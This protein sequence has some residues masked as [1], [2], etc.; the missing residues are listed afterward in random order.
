M[1]SH[2]TL[3]SIGI[4]RNGDNQAGNIVN[5]YFFNSQTLPLTKGLLHTCLLLKDLEGR[6][7]NY[8]LRFFH[9]N[10]WPECEA[11]GP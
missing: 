10:I 7:I 8:G 1:L 3:P 6:T 4:L 5:I 9:F 2:L 11:G